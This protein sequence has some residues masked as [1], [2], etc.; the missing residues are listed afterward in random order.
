MS[1]DRT[2]REGIAMALPKYDELYGDVLRWLGSMANRA[3]RSCAQGSP[4]SAACPPRTCRSCSPAERW[5][6][7]A[8]WAGP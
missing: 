8:A 3:G 6:G 7:R 4:P 2:N 1:A 5:C